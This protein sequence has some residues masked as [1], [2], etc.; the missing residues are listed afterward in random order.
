MK[1]WVPVRENQPPHG[2]MGHLPVHCDHLNSLP[3]YRYPL[4]SADGLKFRTVVLELRL[5]IRP[6][7]W[8]QEVCFPMRRDVWDTLKQ[9]L[10]VE[11]RA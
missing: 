4:K 2:L 6:D 9:R 5:F 11:I 10:D 3:S 8:T 7:R 1:H